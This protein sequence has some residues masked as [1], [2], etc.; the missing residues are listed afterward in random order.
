[1]D[2]AV[3]LDRLRAASSPQEQLSALK[4]LKNDIIGHEQK[5]ET[6]IR[7]GVVDLLVQGLSRAGKSRGK[8]RSLLPGSP[9]SFATQ[10][11]TDSLLEW[12][13]EDH[14]KLQTVF[15]ITSLAHGGSYHMRRQ[16]CQC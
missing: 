6:I 1:M 7:D 5:K 8:K 3:S 14:V 11:D 4:Q 15:I 10:S 13:I 12:D 9:S 16:Q 2:S